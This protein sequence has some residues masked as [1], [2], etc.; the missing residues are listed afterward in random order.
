MQDGKQKRERKEEKHVSDNWVVQNLNNS[1]ESWNEKLAEVWDLLT[2]SPEEFRGGGIWTVIQD[3]HGALLAIGLALLVLFFVTGVVKTCGS[4]TEV[5][6][7]EHALKLFVRFAIAKGVVTYGLELMMALF[8]IVQGVISTIMR[9]SGLGNNADLVLPDEMVKAIEDCGFFESIPLWAVTLICSLVITILS[10]IIILS[11]YGRFFKLYI[12]TAIAPIP[13]AAFAGEPTQQIGKS[14]LKSYAAV[15]LEGAIILLACIVFSLFAESPPVVDTQ[16]APVTMVWS[17]V[18]ELVFNMLVLVGAVKM[19]D[20]VVSS[21]LFGCGYSVFPAATASRFGN[22]K[23]DMYY[24]G[25]PICCHRIYP[26]QRNAGRK[27][28]GGIYQVRNINAE[29]TALQEY[30]YIL[31]DYAAGGKREKKRK[32]N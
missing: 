21:G 27:V 15:C 28:S 26:V 9:A 18:G 10:F 16:S 25:F 12:Y 14:F 6:R 5:K 32:E 23:L 20:R 3:I 29:E 11:V 24:C 7:P 4:F 30:Q 19:A 1:L 2:Q 17:Y 31:A 8:Q 22:G 13:L